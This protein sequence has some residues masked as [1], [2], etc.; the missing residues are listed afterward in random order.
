MSL[1]VSL[2]RL[3][4][5]PSSALNSA[6]DLPC[7][8]RLSSLTWCPIYLAQSTLPG[9]FAVQVFVRT[10]RNSLSRVAQHRSY[11]LIGYHQKKCLVISAMSI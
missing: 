8:F 5:A 11:A 3:S 2:S 10:P 7:P 9:P 1:R 4:L 6:S